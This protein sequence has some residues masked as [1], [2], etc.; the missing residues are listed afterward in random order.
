MKTREIRP[1]IFNSNKQVKVSL[2]LVSS[3]TGGTKL[4]L[5][6]CPS[7]VR[8]Y[9]FTA[10]D[11]YRVVTPP[12]SW[13]PRVP[14]P[15]GL[16][17]IHSTV[18]PFGV[19]SEYPERYHSR[20]VGRMNACPV[21]PASSR[22]RS[23]LPLPPQTCKGRR[24]T[25]KAKQRCSNLRRKLNYMN[26]TLPSSRHTVKE[27]TKCPNAFTISGKRTDNPMQKIHRPKL[28]YPPRSPS[29]T[30][31]NIYLSIPT[32]APTCSGPL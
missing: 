11:D 25:G 18:A 4:S 17:W 21:T 20:S 24:T 16:W 3:Q 1:S 22:S 30:R 14:K 27:Q 32:P 7:R 19:Y 9:W 6:C 29:V 12:P 8:T 31:Q 2:L 26:D 23:Q 28:L 5:I 13:T 10:T 15:F